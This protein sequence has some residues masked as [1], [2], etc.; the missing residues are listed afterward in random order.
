MRE[1]KS[2]KG[3]QSPTLLQLA[4]IFIQFY[5]HFI[6]PIAMNLP[7]RLGVLDRGLEERKAHLLKPKIFALL[8]LERLFDDVRGE[9]QGWSCS[10][11]LKQQ[12]L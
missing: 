6:M 2:G 4:D 3:N 8:V 10:S 1:C 7:Q 11:L 9:R 12:Q 5:I